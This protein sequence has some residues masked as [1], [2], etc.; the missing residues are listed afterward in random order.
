MIPACYM[1][2]LIIAA[3]LLPA[4]GGGSTGQAGTQGQ[5]ARGGQGGPG[6]RGG[7]PVTVPTT[8]VERISIQR[9]VD[10]SGTLASLDQVRVSS[11]A[12]GVIESVNAELGQ[13]VRAGQVLIQIDTR[14]LELGL[15]RV[16]SALRQTEAQLGINSQT[17]SFLRTTRSR[18]FG[19]PLPIGTTPEPNLPALRNWSVRD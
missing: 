4:C 9:Q 11:E 12:S 15:V 19:P 16:E 10:L 17:E 13:E 2:M 8:R 18:L 14:E 7:Q 3:L 5:D 1:Y 6:N